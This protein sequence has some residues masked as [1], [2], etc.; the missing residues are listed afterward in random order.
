MRAADIDP[1]QHWIWRTTPRGAH[2]G[3][4][5]ITAVRWQPEHRRY[6]VRIDR[7]EALAN[8]L[9][10]H[11]YLPPARRVTVRRTGNAREGTGDAV[12]SPIQ[13]GHT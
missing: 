1:D 9:A 12:P 5:L 10:N 7:P 8:C 13:E 11:F 6:Y 3:W 4:Y 2:G